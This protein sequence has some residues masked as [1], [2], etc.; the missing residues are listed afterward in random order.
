MTVLP[1]SV[2]VPVAVLIVALAVDVWVY[3]DAR[4][5]LAQGRPVSVSAG[6]LRMETPEGWFLGCLVLWVVFLPLYLTVTGRNPFT[7]SRG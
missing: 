4:K 6:S 3:T 5:R 2:L 7:S 1:L